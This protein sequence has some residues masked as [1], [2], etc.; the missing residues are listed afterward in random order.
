MEHLLRVPWSTAEMLFD[1]TGKLHCF[2]FFLSDCNLLKIYDPSHKENAIKYTLSVK[3]VSDITW[4][5]NQEN[6]FVV[7]M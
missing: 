7:E 5:K 1:A 2:I 3:P 6:W 4:D